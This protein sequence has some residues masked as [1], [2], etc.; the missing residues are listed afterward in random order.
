MVESR[1]VF[2][3]LKV[4]LHKKGTSWKVDIRVVL[5]EI[6]VNSWNPINS[7]QERDYWRT[8]VNATS[9]LPVG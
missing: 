9:I 4:N 6:C 7:A 1:R 2:K 5:K 8:P 3:I